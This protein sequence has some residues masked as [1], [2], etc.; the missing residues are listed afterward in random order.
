MLRKAK[1]QYYSAKIAQQ[2]GDIKQVWKLV[3]EVTGIGVKKRIAPDN[4][5]TN[6]SD[7]F[8]N[9]FTN[10]GKN[11]PAQSQADPLHSC[12]NKIFEE[13]FQ[14]ASVTTEEI[15]S[16]ILK[17]PCNKA[18]GHDG[19][20][21]KVLKAIVDLLSEPL[22][23]IMNNSLQN[24]TYPNILKIARVVPIYKSGDREN[25]S[26]YRPISVLSIVNTLFEKVIRSRLCRFLGSNDIIC[27]EQ[28]GFITNRSTTTA[29]FTLAQF[30]NSVLHD[31]EIAVSVFLDIKKAFDT[32]SHSIL[33]KKLESYYGFTEKTLQLFSSYL[34]ERKQC[35][36]F[37]RISSGFRKITC[38][39]P[40]G[41]VLGPML[42]SLYINDLPSAL[43]RKTIMYADDTA[44]LFRGNS[45]CTLKKEITAELAQISAWF[46]RNKLALNVA[47][48]KY[49]IFHSRRK[50]LDYS[51]LGLEI[52]NAPI[53]RVSAFK[54]LGVLID[55][56]LN[57]KDE[58]NYISRKLAFA[59]FTL[60][61]AKCYFPY[62]VLRS[63]YF[64]IFHTQ[65][66][67]CSEIWGFT[68]LTYTEPIKRLQKRALRIITASSS[69]C[70]S[71][72]L[73][74]STRIL[75]FTSQ[76]N[77]KTAVLI[78]SII[79]TNFPLPVS[80][81]STPTRNTRHAG[82]GNFNLPTC[83]NVYGERLIQFTGAKI[84]NTIPL[85][86][87]LARNFKFTC[88]MHFV[89]LSCS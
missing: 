28:H 86:I 76:R 29:V 13:D 60:I 38:G 26:S 2:S 84:W 70:P 85:E 67:Y 40:Q 71:S 4:P 49:I 35:V 42:F 72:D 77:Y 89:S 24:G 48:T 55:E 32:V 51:H 12:Q 31:N 1:K 34:A 63:L 14:L 20:T 47:K 68:Y 36:V 3:R 79:N 53:E 10:V 83:R 74:S 7:N 56:N 88:K 61:K 21:T 11:F 65:L 16:E 82:N 17:L 46:A 69:S 58:V 33:L 54:Y 41:T 6:T 81:F 27:P 50:N 37:D 18:V 15:R 64:S 30:V 66:S 22:S 87:K 73:F 59:C 43:S 8:N 39:I 57:W 5:T 9:F 44:L 19:I 75:P 23:R 80:T 78:N 45:L 52:D 25:P 62:N